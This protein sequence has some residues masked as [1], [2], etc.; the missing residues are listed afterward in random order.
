MNN[1]VVGKRVT[2]GM[3]VG[4]AVSF[5]VWLWNAKH[6]EFQ[7]PAEQA[8]GIT[9]VITGIGQVFIAN[10]FGITDAE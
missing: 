9:T 5:A 6:P 4:G 3:I 10:K 1:I 8:V 7:V 2:Y